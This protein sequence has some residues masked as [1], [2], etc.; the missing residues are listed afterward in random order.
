MAVSR[1]RSTTFL[2]APIQNPFLKKKNSVNETRQ[3][4]VCPAGRLHWHHLQWVE[5]SVTSLN[6]TADKLISDHVN[7]LSS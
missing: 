2:I 6:E 3:Y 5:S 4:T 1:M 7:Q